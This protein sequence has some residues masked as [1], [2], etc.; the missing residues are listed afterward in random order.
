MSGIVSLVQMQFVQLLN[1]TR[2]LTFSAKT[3]WLQVAKLQLLFSKIQ[4]DKVSY[5]Y[6][7]YI[8]YYNI[9]YNIYKLMQPNTTVLIFHLQLCNLQLQLHNCTIAQLH[10][11]VVNIE[12]VPVRIS[13]GDD[14]I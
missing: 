9:I 8:L 5:I 2:V 11:Q 12:I 14:W 10:K 6:I 3:I 4:I 1:S 7:Y 13:G